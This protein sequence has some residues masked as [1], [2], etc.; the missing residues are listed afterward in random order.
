MTPPAWFPAAVG[1]LAAAFLA[2]ALVDLSGERFTVEADVW[3]L[4]LGVW[5][6]G[7]CLLSLWL[8][9]RAALA[10]ASPGRT[11]G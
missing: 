11:R 7:A 6:A 8:R 9:R 1:L 4:A 2:F 5:C 10:A 3:A